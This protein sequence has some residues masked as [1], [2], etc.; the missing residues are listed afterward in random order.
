MLGIVAFNSMFARYRGST[1]IFSASSL[2]DIPSFSRVAYTS[3]PKVSKPGQS[4]TFAINS[5]PSTI[6]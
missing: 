1:P 6:V 4:S 5:S 3:A 2:R